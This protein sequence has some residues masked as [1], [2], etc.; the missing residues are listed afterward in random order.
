MMTRISTTT[1]RL[2][3]C[4]ALIAAFARSAA[5]AEVRICTNLGAIDVELDDQNAP[6]HTRNF[7]DYANSGFYSGT[8]F[9]RVVP[10]T[11]V[12][13]GS[14]DASL[15]RR[16]PREPVAS[17]SQNGLSNLRGTIA[18][19]RGADPDSATSQFFFNLSDNTHLDA[20][21]GN[22][23]YTVFGRVT[24]GLDVLDAISRLPTRTAGELTDVPVPLVTLE[25]VT[26]LQRSRTFGLSVEPDPTAL[27]RQFESAAASGDAQSILASIDDLRRSCITLDPAQSVA[28]AE[29]ASALGNVDRARYALEQYLA[30]ADARDSERARAERL[31]AGLP[32]PRQSDI[33]ARV[34]HCRQ[35]ASPSIPNGRFT[36]LATMQT[37]EGSI[38]RFRQLGRLYLSCLAQVMDSGEL[39]EAESI[40]ATK[41]YND[42][43]VEIT[44]VTT[45]FNTAARE[46][47]QTLN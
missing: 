20:T 19:S 6:R 10:D 13:G 4:G 8:V 15:E 3:L 5:A 29:A 43:V 45:R 38:L 40:D 24:A 41:I 7:L 9:H 25:S 36:D 18:A 37:V 28:E 21:A 12:Q 14:Y 39:N 47:K 32:T 2:C 1:L 35:P 33:A 27:Q 22:P 34:A 42:M 17:E 46:F 23:G 44:N 11:M 16:R 26:S 30:R 31:Y